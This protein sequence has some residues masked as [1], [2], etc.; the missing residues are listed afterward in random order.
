MFVEVLFLG[1]DVSRNSI[2]LTDISGTSEMVE[3]VKT[4]LICHIIPTR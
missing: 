3:T 1:L 4:Y 2:L